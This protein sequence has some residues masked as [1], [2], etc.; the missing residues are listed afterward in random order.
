MSKDQKSG[1]FKEESLM[2]EQRSISI[3]SSSNEAFVPH[4]ATLFLSLL[5]TKQPHT[6]F[7]FYVIDDNISLRSK[8]LLNR[9]VGEYNARISYV[10]IDPAEFSGAVV[11]RLWNP[12]AFYCS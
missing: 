10:T 3:V 12:I 6:T 7:H 5:T 9:T 8:F 4:L 2:V 11:S 1:N